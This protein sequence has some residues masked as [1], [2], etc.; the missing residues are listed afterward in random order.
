MELCANRT[1]ADEQKHTIQNR[2]FV[3]IH[4]TVKWNVTNCFF[5][6]RN[7]TNQ[8]V[9]I[10]IPYEWNVANCFVKRNKTNQLVEIPYALILH[11]LATSKPAANNNTGHGEVLGIGYTFKWK[12]FRDRLCR[13]VSA[14][15]VISSGSNI[16][17]RLLFPWLHCCRPRNL[18]ASRSCCAFWIP[19]IEL[20][21]SLLCG[22]PV[23][24]P[25]C[26][27]KGHLTFHDRPGCAPSV[28]QCTH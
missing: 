10:D 14:S 28:R 4:E 23:V 6:K 9:E 19:I 3:T 15:S 7:K 22:V 17:R 16:D 26:R 2:V 20:N 1:R 18:Q 12:V 24:C 13:L 11:I 27:G 5:V 25:T 8:L 21:G